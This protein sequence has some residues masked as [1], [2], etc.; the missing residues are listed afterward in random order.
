MARI[1][2]SL[3]YYARCDTDDFVANSLDRAIAV[4]ALRLA[5]FR[6][7]PFLHGFRMVW[8]VLGFGI[9]LLAFLSHEFGVL[10][11]KFIPFVKRITGRKEIHM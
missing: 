6:K 11:A 7:Y 1:A 4:S 3:E 8:I 9:E 10:H 2:D 5:I